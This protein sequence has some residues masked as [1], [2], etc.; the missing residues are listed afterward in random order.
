MTH[1]EPGLLSVHRTCNNCGQALLGRYG[2]RF[3]CAEC[4]VAGQ[5]AEA[6]AARRLWR[7]MGRPREAEL[8]QAS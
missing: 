8:E 6:K 3:C 7:E 1:F 5:S 2:Q 4:R